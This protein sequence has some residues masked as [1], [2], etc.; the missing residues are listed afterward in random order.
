MTTLLEIHSPHFQL[1]FEELCHSANIN[2]ETMLEL[3]QNDIAIPITGAKPQQWLFH[4]TCVIKVKK[5]AR[6]YHDLGINWADVYLVLNLL[7]EIEQLKNENEQ[8]KQQL[9]RFR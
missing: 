2:K 5:A 4:V 8:L 7:E 1:S 6:L 3:V 9:G